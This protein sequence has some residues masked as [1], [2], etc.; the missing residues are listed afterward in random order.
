MGKK[1]RGNQTQQT[2]LQSIEAVTADLERV[3]ASAKAAGI[4]LVE[5]TSVVGYLAAAGSIK[6]AAELGLTGEITM[7]QAQ[8]MGALM[9]A[10]Q[11]RVQACRNA[12][13]VYK[14][15]NRVK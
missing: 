13:K 9:G 6:R 3:Y 11:T 15:H 12:I 8:N 4:F 14:K 2:Q 7:T 5:Q 10:G 1:K